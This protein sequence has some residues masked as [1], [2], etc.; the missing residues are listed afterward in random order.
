M[1]ADRHPNVASLRLRSI[2]RGAARLYRLEPA[3]VAGASLLILFPAV[4]ISAG[5]HSIHTSVAESLGENDPVVLLSVPPA[6]AGFVAILG[7]VLL[8][9]VMDELVGAQIRGTAMPSVTRAVTSLPLGRLVAAD[10]LVTLLISIASAA[11]AIPGL[12]LGALVGIVGPVVNIERVGPLAAVGRSLRLTWRH[13]WLAIG[14]LVPMLLVEIAVH[15]VLVRV[16]DR[17]GLLAEVLVEVVLILTVG[18][19]VALIEVVFA[20]ALMARDPGS[21]VATM[22]QPTS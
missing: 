19:S 3:R 21:R 20:Y 12:V 8:G 9:G 2:Y 14:A 1:P 7:L 17:L 4:L 10:V 13:A 5:I 11:G 6:L 22:I 15:A 16:W 18:A